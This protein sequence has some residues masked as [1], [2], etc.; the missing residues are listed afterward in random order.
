MAGYMAD[1][2]EGA[3][4]HYGLHIRY[5]GI[6]NEK[7]Y[8]SEYVKQL[9]RALNERKLDTKIVC[10]DEYYGQHQWH[11]AKAIRADSELRKA[12]DV[13]GVHYPQTEDGALT[14]IGEA[15]A[16]GKP[17]WSSEDQPNPGGGPFLPRIW[18]VGG[19]ILASVYNRNYL[20]GSLTK[21]E[22]WSPITSYYDNL[23]APNSGLMYA[24]T[25]WSGYYDVQST[26]WVTAH[27]TQFTQPG[28]QYVDSA[29][30]H[31]PDHGTYVTLR[32]PDAQDWSVIAETIGARTQQTVQFVL[33]GG[34]KSAV[35]HVWETNAEQ[36]FE[37]VS[38]AKPVNGTVSVTLEPESL[39]TL[40]TTEGQGKGKA[41]PPVNTPFPFPY[42]EDFEKTILGRA[43][44][45]F[46]DQDGAFEAH[47]CRGRNGQCLEQ[48]ISQKPIPW[49]PL[50]D[51]YTMAGDANWSD[52]TLSA[53]VRIDG[54]SAVTLIGRIDS[55]NAFADANARWPSGYVLQLNHDGTWLLFS[56]SFKRAP[57]VLASG[58]LPKS[59]AGWHSL[60]LAFHET[61]ITAAVDD[62]QLAEVQD[63][64]HTAGMVA[65]GT[66]W[67][68]AQFDNVSVRQ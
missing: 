30:G 48:V 13:I 38:D 18:N 40:T 55:A 34:L 63:Q 52:Y 57:Q 61:K 19:K 37:H 66:D 23:A 46:A 43:A 32:S 8:D 4:K 47:P 64:T 9:R 45:F 22:I 17:L 62:R 36:T 3:K 53:D 31:L 26:I 25:P 65:L 1:F 42:S 15:R 49:G 29:S 50:P 5:T 21:T 20:E 6:W 56:E 33:R 12:V 11:I 14:T 68:T 27:T 60:R 59:A 16:S 2:I 41:Q 28:W 51:P 39:Y 54:A 24:N 10:C 7:E 67:G 35:V 58:S 44:R